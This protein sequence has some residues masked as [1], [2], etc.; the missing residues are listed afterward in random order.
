MHEQGLKEG[1]VAELCRPI[2][3]STQKWWLWRLRQRTRP[4]L[5][6][7]GAREM[8]GGDW[9]SDEPFL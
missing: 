2:D 7:G 6:C 9:E 8:S 5:G 3:G 1:P 4:S